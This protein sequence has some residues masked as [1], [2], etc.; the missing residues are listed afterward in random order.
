M[1][2]TLF[3]LSQALQWMKS[4]DIEGKGFITKQV[5]GQSIICMILLK[6]LNTDHIPGVHRWFEE[7]RSGHKSLS[8][9]GRKR[10]KYPNGIVKPVQ[11]NCHQ[12]WNVSAVK[13]W[14]IT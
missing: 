14:K 8:H 11:E 4:I 10:P 12:G 13:Q 9:D 6:S 2:F 5:P 3:N 7:S 1:E